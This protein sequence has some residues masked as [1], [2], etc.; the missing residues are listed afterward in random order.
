M[1]PF[2][3]R[4]TGARERRLLAALRR[5]R[6]AA[7]PRDVADLIPAFPL[8]IQIQST[9]RCNAACVMCP[10][11]GIT[12]EPGFTHHLMDSALYGEILSQLRGR[13]VERLSLFLMNEPLLDVRMVEWVS[14]ARQALPDVTLGLF[15]NGSPLTPDLARDL[16]TA[17]LDEL[18][19]SFHGFDAASYERVMRGL[20]FERAR[21]NVEQV[22]ALH[23]AGALGRLHLQ[24]VAGDLPEIDLRAARADPLLRDFIVFKPFSNENAAAGVGSDDP[25]PAPAPQGHGVCQRPFVKLYILTNGDC[26]MCNVDWRRTVVLGRVSREPDGQIASIWR[27]AR[28]RALRASHLAGCFEGNPACARCDYPRTAEDL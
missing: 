14:L 12:S 10:Y 11:D 5:P 6:G 20:S 4:T 18:C 8:K 24:L 3:E 26:V 28:Y 23:R 22:V 16:A 1:R 27:G 15:T 7:A 2:D 25:A 13:G 17:G 21:R 19:I 9:T